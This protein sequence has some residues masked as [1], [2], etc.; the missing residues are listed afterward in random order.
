MKSTAF[1]IKALTARSYLVRSVVVRNRTSTEHLALGDQRLRTGLRRGLTACMHFEQ[2]RPMRDLN[3][4]VMS[5]PGEPS[6]ADCF[7]SKP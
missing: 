2:A 1:E 6:M 7:S 3:E 4:E 5:A